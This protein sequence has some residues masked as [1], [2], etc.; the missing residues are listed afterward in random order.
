MKKTSKLCLIIA[1]IVLVAILV[2]LILGYY[3]KNT[4]EI[5]NPIATME[6]ENYGIIKL[7]LYPD[8]A[9]ETVKN[10]ITLANNG[11]YDGLKFHR[12]VKD[13]MIQGGDPKGDGSGG[14]TFADLYNNK[15]EN[16][17]YKYSNGDEA[18]SSDQYTIKGEFLANGYKVNNLNLTEG[19]I[20]MARGD[21]GTS[22]T[23]LIKEGY[24]SAGSQFFIMTTNDYTSLSGY[25][26]GF[27]KV[28]E[29]M[30]VVKKIAEVECTSKESEGAENE[31]GNSNAEIST[32]VT[33]VIISSIKVETNGVNYGLPNTLKPFNYMKWLY[34]QYGLTYTEPEESSDSDE[35]EQENTP[36]AE[37]ETNSDTE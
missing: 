21:Y 9:P 23:T 26:A 24:N 20:A 32:P 8:L 3:K 17:K 19:T 10:F 37:V 22:S 29:G 11:V 6:I 7:E 16:V 35:Q 14:P 25:Y 30:D 31:E 15:D 28:V 34:S 18:K 2:V 12:V 5:R 33:D 13:F 1:L 27:G 36:E 4:L